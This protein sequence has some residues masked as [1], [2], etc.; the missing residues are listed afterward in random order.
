MKSTNVAER[1]LSAHR[2]E[3]T[4]SLW[5]RMTLHL[6]CATALS[7]T[8]ACGPPEGQRVSDRLAS[9]KRA[10]AAGSSPASSSA[11]RQELLSAFE[12]FLPGHPVPTKLLVGKQHSTRFSAW[13]R[14][15]GRYGSWEVEAIQT[16]HDSQ[17]HCPPWGTISDVQFSRPAA[18]RTAREDVSKLVSELLEVPG[19]DDQ[20]TKRRTWIRNAK[21]GRSV[22]YATLTLE[23]SDPIKLQLG[24]AAA[25]EVSF[26]NRNA[27]EIREHLGHAFP[28]SSPRD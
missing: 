8:L 25:S 16:T 26:R 5:P 14:W 28:A 1:S 22:W 18:E 13:R 17:W 11:D 4:R 3:S 23:R 20:E 15:Q 6:I 24:C 10:I 27:L 21:N 2:R 9:M 7:F 19:T 12:V